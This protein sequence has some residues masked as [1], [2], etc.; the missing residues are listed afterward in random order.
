LRNF[1]YVGYAHSDG[2]RF[3]RQALAA[4]LARRGLSLRYYE[5]D[6]PLSGTYQDFAPWME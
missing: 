1:A 3:R 2:S 4:E 6:K 5:T